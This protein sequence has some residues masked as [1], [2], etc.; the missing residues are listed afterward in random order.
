[1]SLCENETAIEKM[2]DCVYEKERKRDR[3]C[4]KEKKKRECAV[5]LCQRET[6]TDPVRD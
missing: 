2:V 1:M 3:R 4:M 6:K 5:C